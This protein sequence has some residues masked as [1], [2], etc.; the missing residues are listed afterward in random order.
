MPSRTGL[1]APVNHEETWKRAVFVL[2]GFLGEG[3]ADE[4]GV[5]GDA[6][7]NGGACVGGNAAVGTV[8]GVFG[9]VT[10][11][12]FARV[13]DDGGL[14][15][16][17][18]GRCGNGPREVSTVEG[19]GSVQP[20]PSLFLFSARPLV[21]SGTATP[22]AFS[23]AAAAAAPASCLFSPVASSRTRSGPLS[24]SLPPPQ[25][26]LALRAA[27]LLPLFAASSRAALPRFLPASP[28]TAAVVLRIDPRFDP[29]GP[30]RRSA[31][32]RALVRVA[33]ESVSLP[34][35]FAIASALLALAER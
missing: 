4:G 2:E 17:A 7:D 32:V 6:G 18:S 9:S 33:S 3:G 29:A 1:E 27:T 11:D 31:A 24:R 22:P 28:A 34:A 19:A 16:A 23:A 21:L 10:G 26:S 30:G 15:A 12:D 25:L 14:V 8:T 20:F 13:C 5:G 35:V